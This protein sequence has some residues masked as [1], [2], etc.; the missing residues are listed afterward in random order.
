MS[1]FWNALGMGTNENNSN[2]NSNNNNNSNSNS[3][4]SARTP[5]YGQKLETPAKRKAQARNDGSLISSIS[6]APSAAPS[7]AAS[8]SSRNFEGSRMPQNRLG[9]LEEHPNNSLRIPKPK[10]KPKT[11]P[12]LEP[13]SRTSSTASTAST[14]GNE[15]P[16][17]LI[18]NNKTSL[19]VCENK[20]KFHKECICTHVNSKSNAKCPMCRG[21]I[22]KTVVDKC[23]SVKGGRK[24]IKKRRT[25][26]RR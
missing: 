22:K 10:P 7:A 9:F 18:A 2:S 24:S 19:Q 20:H 13:L 1:F 8:R 23:K 25:N 3:G 16:I 14:S 21:D 6:E 12:Q 15:C 11:P 4:S 17:C 26:K 5:R